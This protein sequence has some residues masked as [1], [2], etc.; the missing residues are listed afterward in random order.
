MSKKKDDPFL[1]TDDDIKGTKSEVAKGSSGVLCPKLNKSLEG[2]CAVCDYIS[3]N[4]YSKYPGKQNQEHSARK[5]AGNKKGKLNWFMNVVFP[6]NPD[7][8]FVAEV[9]AKGGS[10]IIEG[11][12]KKG[13][14]DICHPHKNKGRMMLCTKSKVDGYPFYSMSPE[15]EK[16]DWAIPDEVWKDLPDLK[17]VVGM[18]ERGELNDENFVK[19]SAIMKMDETLKFRICPP[20]TLEGDD[21]RW[22]IASVVRHWG[23]TQAQIDGDA[24]ISWEEGDVDDENKPDVVGKPDEMELPDEKVDAPDEE[25]KDKKEEKPKCFGMA[26]FYEDDDED[27]MKCTWFKKCGKKVLKG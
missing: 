25:V 3:A 15:L 11:M 1:I 9:G 26:K 2:S 6:E 18:I 21:R 14:K 10:M 4:I 8:S 17:D 12:E 13:W 16:A 19:F 23:V 7:K 27:C 5:W 20:K 24:P 22:W